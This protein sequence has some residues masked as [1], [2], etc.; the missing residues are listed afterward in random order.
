MAL[1]NSALLLLQLISFKL[2]KK[3]NTKHDYSKA[4]NLIDFGYL[5]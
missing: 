3:Q 5:I 1:I 2:T 4:H